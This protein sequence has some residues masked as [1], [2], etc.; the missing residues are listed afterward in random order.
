MG[1]NPLKGQPPQ[2]RRKNFK[3]DKP[4]ILILTSGPIAHK[5][6]VIQKEKCTPMFTAVV[7]P[8]AKTQTQD[9]V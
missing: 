6:N 9:K 1:N 8:V 2:A 7:P 3:T 5:K 4:R